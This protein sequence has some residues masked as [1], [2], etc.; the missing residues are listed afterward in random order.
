MRRNDIGSF[1]HWSDDVLAEPTVH[2]W[3]PDP[4]VLFANGRSAILALAPILQNKFGTPVLHLPTFFDMETATRLHEAFEIHWYRDLPTES[5][6]DFESLKPNPG[7]AILILN[8]FGIRDGKGW[9][10]WRSGRQVV[11]IEDHTHDPL[12]TWARESKADFAI[13]SLRKTLPIPDGGILWS[14]GGHTL[15]SPIVPAPEAPMLRLAA[16]VLRGAYLHGAAV[17][18]DVVRSLAVAGEDGLDATSGA[19]ISPFTQSILPCIDVMARRTQRERNVLRFLDGLPP[20]LNNGW[21]PLFTAWP[22]GATPFNAVLLCDSFEVREAL[23]RYLASQAIYCPVHWP[24]PYNGVSSGDPD[25]I[26]LTTRVLTIPVDERYN[27]DAI[28]RV[29]H[30]LSSFTH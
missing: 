19:A 11:L 10:T 21:Q 24:Q 6:P 5:S 9:E 28:Q 16:M 27:I 23:Q 26:A 20:R 3:L 15:P 17:S 30:A 12:S 4:A 7:D 25:V 13:A 29:V 1:F 22:D 14:P 2:P 8:P 18:P